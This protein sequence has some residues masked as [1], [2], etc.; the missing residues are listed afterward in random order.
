MRRQVAVI[1]VSGST[2]VALAAKAA[3]TTIPIVFAV[4][5]DPVKFGL[6]ASFNRSG[7]NITGVS[8][9][10]NMLTTKQF[11]LLHE[12]VP[13]AAAVGFLVNPANPNAEPDSDMR[14]FRRRF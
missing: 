1:V 13:K 10:A 14:R 3:T 11:E 2:A 12:I 7:G 8:F 5:G 4:G 9:L 6:V